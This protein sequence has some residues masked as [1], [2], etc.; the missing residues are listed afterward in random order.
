M[1]SFLHQPVTA[2]VGGGEWAGGETGVLAGCLG[3]I[4]H[5]VLLMLEQVS[6]TKGSIICALRAPRGDPKPQHRLRKSDTF[7]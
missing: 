5:A 1:A 4:I 7:S 3:H 2:K 6:K